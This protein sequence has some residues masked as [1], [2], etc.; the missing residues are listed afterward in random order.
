MEDKISIPDYIYIYPSK[1]DIDIKFSFENKD[2]SIDEITKKFKNKDDFINLIKDYFKELYQYDYDY[3][4]STIKENLKLQ[5][6]FDDFYLLSI[7]ERKYIDDKDKYKKYIFASIVNLS[8]L[9][10]KS[11]DKSI[12][13]ILKDLKLFLETK[14]L[15]FIL[16]FLNDFITSFIFNNEYLIAIFIDL[17]YNRNI[18]LYDFS[19]F[20]SSDFADD[21]LR[22]SSIDT[23]SLAEAEEE[24]V[25]EEAEAEEERV[26]R[27]AEEERVARVA[28]VAEEAEAEEERVARVAE[29]AEAEEERVAR[30]A[31]EERV[32]RVAEEE[33]V[34]RVAE[35]QSA[36]EKIKKIIKLLNDDKIENKEDLIHEINVLL[37]EIKQINNK[38]V[39]INTNKELNDDELKTSNI[40]NL[41]EELNNQKENLE[42]NKENII[43]TVK[44][45]QEIIIKIQ[46]IE[47]K[48]NFDLIEQI[49]TYKEKFDTELKALM[50]TFDLYKL[51]EEN[52]NHDNYKLTEQN[53]I[54]YNAIETLAYDKDLRTTTLIYTINDT[55]LTCGYLLETIFFDITKKNL[56][57]TGKTATIVNNDTLDIPNKLKLLTDLNGDI[58]NDIN[59]TILK[60]NNELIINKL[61]SISTEFN[62]YGY[63]IVKLTPII[64]LMGL[65][66]DNTANLVDFIKISN[67]LLAEN[68]NEIISNNLVEKTIKDLIGSDNKI[69]ETLKKLQED[70]IKNNDYK[71][72]T[73]FLSKVKTEKSNLIAILKN[74]IKEKYSNF[75]IT[76]SNTISELIKNFDIFQ[77]TLITSDEIE[78]IQKINDEI[79][80][81]Y[82]D[83][84]TNIDN[85]LS[86]INL[87]EINVSNRHNIITDY[88]K[89][90]KNDPLTT[91]V[92]LE[93]VKPAGYLMFDTDKGNDG[94]KERYLLLYNKNIV[95]NIAVFKIGLYIIAAKKGKLVV[96]IQGKKNSFVSIT[97]QNIKD[98]LTK[99]IK[100]LIDNIIVLLLNFNN[101]LNPNDKFKFTPNNIQYI[102]DNI[103]NINVFQPNK[104]NNLIV[105]ILNRSDNE[106]TNIKSIRTYIKEIAKFLH[107][108]INLTSKVNLLFPDTND[109]NDIKA[110]FSILLFYKDKLISD[111][112]K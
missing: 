35:E 108:L 38:F 84:K 24:R 14:D 1:Q 87:S 81:I 51:T 100:P 22:L 9:I 20:N 11:I 83:F 30:V 45:I 72:I 107:E 27:V 110:F 96:E 3:E 48:K 12:L 64:D 95:I 41:E 103:K 75:D 111:N 58:I 93:N 44:K 98:F 23:E 105:K 40:K 50:I 54:V 8:I 101:Y 74:A 53:T 52:T 49:N 57:F 26:A 89:N 46:D 76:T 79:G 102:Y 56:K 106:Y 25:A 86:S 15:I 68:I 78:Q 16:E 42:K 65:K 2:E 99:P 13:D 39:S 80:I 82:N 7:I 73:V 59:E 29:E 10:N 66:V 17:I 90:K 91:I 33:R 32:A 94:I 97:T 63:I 6:S 21:L 60:Y 92:Q 85:I 69:L 67:E 77:S 47:H 19:I 55:L 71:Q 61:K 34:A 5:D 70:I 4:Q 28:R 109:K 36:K 31:E 37:N 112:E 62:F 104:F 18:N 88:Y 43:D